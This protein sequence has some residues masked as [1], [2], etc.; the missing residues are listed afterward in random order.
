ML[1]STRAGSL[2]I[3]LVGASRVIIL[4]ALWNP[5]HELQAVFRAYRYGQTRPV[6]IYRL[7]SAGTME[8][9]IYSRQVGLLSHLLS[10]GTMEEKIYSRQVGLLSH[11]LSAGTMEEKIYSRQVGLLSHLLSAG[12]MEEKIYSRQVGLLSH[13]WSARLPPT[14]RRHHGGEDLQPPGGSL[15]TPLVST[16]TAYSAQA[17]WRRRSTAAR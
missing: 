9:K 7:L 15:V 10:A 1:I 12:T 3:N 6:H 4:D 13:R 8:E 17:P 11:L 2:G 16:S 14:Q 5:S